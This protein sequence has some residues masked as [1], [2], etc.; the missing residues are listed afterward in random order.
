VSVFTVQLLLMGRY[1]SEYV[2][3][4]VTRR[5]V[6]E[7]ILKDVYVFY[8]PKLQIHNMSSSTF[9]PTLAGVTAEDMMDGALWLVTPCSLAEGRK[10]QAAG[11]R[12]SQLRVPFLV[13]LLLD[14]EGVGETSLPDTE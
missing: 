12:L 14:R 3:T 2:L 11:D 1:Y 9:E 6:P 5:H 8:Y 13:G 7:D 10:K 4:R